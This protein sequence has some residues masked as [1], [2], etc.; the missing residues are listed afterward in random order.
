MAAKQ[1]INQVLL[2]IES[3]SN[4]VEQIIAM[5]WAPHVPDTSGLT[6][7]AQINIDMTTGCKTSTTSQSIALYATQLNAIKYLDE[8]VTRIQLCAV[9]GLNNLT[10]VLFVF[11]SCR[12]LRLRT[13]L[14]SWR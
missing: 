1:R 10:H 11:T 12:L 6:L 4:T 13:S 2:Q 5:A 8:V 7:P 9:C 3:T 14:V